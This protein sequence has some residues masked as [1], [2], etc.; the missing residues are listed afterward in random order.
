MELQSIGLSVREN[1]IE[2]H[3][4][5]GSSSGCLGF[6]IGRILAVFMNM[7]P[8]YSLPSFESVGF[9]VL[10]KFKINLQNGGCGHHLG[11]PIGTILIAIF[12]IF[13]SLRYFLP[14]F[15]P[16]GLSVQEKKF[17]IDF[18]DGGAITKTCLFKYTKT[19]ITKNGKFSD[20][21]M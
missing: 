6:T 2:I 13:K 9:S 19:F 1:K 4:Q 3:F 18:Q 8:R 17:K 11:F 14:N 16:S 10:K 20:K 12:F 7:P 15:E 21:K 5:D